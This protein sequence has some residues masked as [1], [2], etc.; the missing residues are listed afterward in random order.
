M[1]DALTDFDWWELLSDRSFLRDPY[2][3]LAQLRQAG[4]I[5]RDAS[6]GIYFVLGHQA[7]TQVAKAPEMGRDTRLWTDGWA[8]PGGAQQ[9]PVGHRI[10]SAVMPQMINADPPDHARMR[11]V[12]EATFHPVS[13]AEL[14]PMITAEARALVDA[15]P[16]TGTVDVIA[17]LA[18]PLPIRVMRNLLEIPASMD[19]QTGAWS[20][21]LTRLNDVMLT[22][23]QKCEAQTAL[24]SFKDFL[25]GHLQARRRCPRRGMIADV[26]AAGDEG[27]LTEEE[28]LINL[29]TMLIAGHETTVTLIGNGLLML[30]QHPA[31]LAR[32]RADRGLMRTT[33]EECLRF[34]PGTNLNIKVARET[35]MVAGVEIPRGALV[36]GLAGAINRDP[37][38]FERPDEVD[39]G[40][41]PNPHISFGSGI[42]LCIG[43]PLAR[44]EA[45]IAFD[46]LL[47][48][49]P[50]LSLAG[51]PEWRLDSINVRGLRRLLVSVK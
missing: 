15:M 19:A 3:V 20:V 14:A 28:A 23:E 4:P 13:I 27:V 2:P 17:Q 47:D 50:D 39:I 24:D 11:G 45:Q 48:R 16:A 33:V 6:S 9:D 8:R 10:Y 26:I 37:S 30:L 43:A 38:R 31:E 49:F 25:R 29:V 18:A 36:I 22:Q 5:H 7:F 35:L 34:W 46:L 12:F 1:T 44:L 40:R 41:R 32:L 51:D 42:H 21:A